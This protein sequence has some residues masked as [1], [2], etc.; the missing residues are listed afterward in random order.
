MDA[1]LLTRGFE[2]A[3]LDGPV[4][5]RSH[6]DYGRLRRVWN[7]MVDRRP[8][9]IV[10]AMNA[11]DVVKVVQIAAEREM[12]LAVRCGGHSFPGL[13]TCDDGIVL[14]L[15]LM[16]DI[17]VDPISRT[18]EVSGGALLGD[19]DA[20][21]SPYGLVTPAGV[22]SHTGVAGLTLGGGMGWLSRRFG[23]TIDSLLGAE[24][25]TADGRLVRTSSQEE[26]ELFWAIRGGG[27][28]FGVVT[29][30]KFG[31][32]S[33]GTAAVGQ[34]IF[35][36]SEAAAALQRYRECLVGAPR[37][38]TTAFVL[39]PANLRITA[40]W[41]G[42]MEGAETALAG[43]GALG[44]I[45]SSSIGG[46]TFLE[47]QKASDERMAW[48]RRCYAKGG[49]L[50]DIDENTIKLVTDA[51]ISAPT[52]DAEVYVLQLGGAV[53]DTDESDTPYV[54]RAAGYYW[55]VAPVW[56]GAADDENCVAWGRKTA[57]NLA[58][59]S[60]RGNYVN[61]QSETGLAPSAYGEEKYARLAQLKGRYD[62]ANLFRLNQNIEPRL[63]G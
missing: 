35:P 13:S 62:P 45:D 60:L 43:F 37:E 26:P 11:K 17:L 49:F 15:S 46:T 63:K 52:A 1:T 14:D 18:A 7:G 29:K 5:D 19:L 51:M 34:W 6:A 44:H 20:A 32:H 24:I 47:L 28:N 58:A 57:A 3:R 16:K 8:A 10:R 36:S 22:V 27:G 56:D 59:N 53:C 2:L 12:L 33:L 48:G 31:M 30:F 39:T 40:V 55:I 25:V 4:I 38:L 41:S 9:A 61:E 42:S 23:L 50:L 21:G 54:G